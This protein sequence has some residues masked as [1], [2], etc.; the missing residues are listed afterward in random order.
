MPLLSPD[1][2]ICV[3]VCFSRATRESSKWILASL[4]RQSIII[5]IIITI[6]ISLIIGGRQ[7]LSKQWLSSSR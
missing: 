1:L 3:Q 7:E 6:I 4:S 5:I 2:L